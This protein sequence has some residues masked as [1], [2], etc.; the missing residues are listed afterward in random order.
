MRGNARYKSQFFQGY[1]NL[2][3]KAG[4]MHVRKS[5]TLGYYMPSVRF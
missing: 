3:A 5:N 2:V 4:Y 1:G